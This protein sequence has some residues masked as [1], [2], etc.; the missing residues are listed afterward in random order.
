M[1]VA[2]IGK[3]PP[4]AI[5]VCERLNRVGGALVYDRMLRTFYPEA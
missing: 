1:M 3:M 5:D 2:P 4:R